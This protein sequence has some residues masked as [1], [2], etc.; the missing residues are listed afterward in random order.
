MTLR[1][2]AAYRKQH[3]VCRFPA[4]LQN[5]AAAYDFSSL[6]W[7]EF[8]LHHGAKYQNQLHAALRAIPS[9]NLV[10]STDGAMVRGPR[11]FV[12]S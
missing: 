9:D 10:A 11:P 8:Y 5:F 6:K 3:T 1:W 12:A 7:L 2:L 4:T